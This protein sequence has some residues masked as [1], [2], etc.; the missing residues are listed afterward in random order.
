MSFVL[1]KALT[2][3]SVMFNAIAK[4]VCIALALAVTAAGFSGANASPAA[5]QAVPQEASPAT[6]VAQD[7]NAW[8]DGLVPA[9]LNQGQIS[10]AVVVIVRDGQVIAQRG[11]GYADRA[12]LRPVDPE[13]TLFRVGSVSKLVTWTAVMQLVEQGKISLDQDINT[14]LDFKIPPRNGQPIT[15]RHLLTHSAGFEDSAKYLIIDGRREKPLDFTLDLYLK[16]W[17]PKRVFEAGSTTAYSNYGAAL[18]GYIVSRQ[19]RQTFDDY[20][21]TAIFAPLG[22]TRSTFRQPLP[23]Q[24]RPDM[25]QGYSTA[26]D[27]AKP[28]ELVAATPAGSMSATG[29]DMARFMIA[30][31][32]AGAPLMSKA[33]ATLMH[34]TDVR[35]ARPLPGMALGFYRDD[36]NGYR[37]LGHAG[38]TELFHSDLHLVIDRGVGIFVSTNSGGK[39]EW[40]SYFFTAFM[41]RYF[42]APLSAAKSAQFKPSPAHATQLARTYWSNRRPVTGPVAF[43]TTLRQFAITINSDGTVSGL[44]GV[45]APDTIKW[46]EID[47]YL[48]QEVG[49]ARQFAAS[50]KDGRVTGVQLGWL[51]PVMIFNPTPGPLLAKWQLYP[52][53]FAAVI[54]LLTVLGWIANPMLRRAYGGRAIARARPKLWLATRLVALCGLTALVLLG[55]FTTMADAILAPATTRIDTLIISMQVMFALA[56]LGTIVALA[57]LIAAW[58]DKLTLWSIV[59]ALAMLLACLGFAWFAY[60]QN[61]LTMR[62]DY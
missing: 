17:V 55:V 45:E 60:S 2:A 58:R 52:L 7:A 51:P 42:P 54:Y 28:F 23:T 29:A 48:W 12:R 22:M 33:T 37:V 61:L 35:R 41:N 49:G 40:R 34:D 46:R 56:A 26:F 9:L 39:Q 36:R 47:D 27:D 6:L 21:D 25:A 53:G 4:H 5:L 10:G 44:P 59:K 19:S 32:A 18:A 43:T 14:Y 15:M 50:V 16:D 20:V 3:A 62:V 30:H 8:L 31:L 11:Y 13:R 38:D 57:N 24:L 1:P